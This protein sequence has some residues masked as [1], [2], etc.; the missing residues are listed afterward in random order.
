[1]STEETPERPRRRRLTVVAVAAAVLVAGGGAAY[2]S[3]A[4]ADD[5]APT[6][7]G[8]GSKP[9]PLALDHLRQ[10]EAATGSRS[11]IAPGEP[12][13]AGGAYRAQGELPKGPGTASV[14]RTEGRVTES[15]VAAVAEVLGMA[16]NP[17][18]EHG[19]WT[20]R[21]SKD[22]SGPSLT[23]SDERAAGSWRFSRYMPQRDSVCAAP[24]KPGEPRS[25]RSCGGEPGEASTTDPVSPEEA[26]AAVRP[27]LKAMN[28]DGARLDASAVD[29]ALR[30][31]SAEPQVGGLPVRHWG[32]VFTVGADGQL[33][34]GRG[35]LAEMTKGAEYPVLS[36][37]KTLK[38]LNKHQ[39]G[40]SSNLAS[41]ASPEQPGKAQTPNP[42]GGDAG[43]TDAGPPCAAPGPLGVTS[44]TDAEFGL[45]MQ[46]SDTGP[47]LVP[48]WIFE[49]E[50]KGGGGTHEVTYPA[51]RPDYLVAGKDGTS[52]TGTQPETPPGTGSE[53]TTRQALTSYRAD[54]RTL[55]VT[56]Y[57]GVCDTY[58]GE[59]KAAK[60]KVTVSVEP[61]EPRPKGPCIA[62]AKE[63]TV[64]VELDEPLGDR[65]VV[66]GRDGEQLPRK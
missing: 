53:D 15:E 48:S 30:E 42:S 9:A 10:T 37:A 60:E 1:M 61:R 26:K 57:G 43:T 18:R 41:C 63:Q 38:E 66:D 7:D 47:L 13:P 32:A 31:V 21:D 39:R 19:G 12:D 23:V 44:V 64:K 36:A 20:V 17:K 35:Q 51:V 52:G 56:F 59:A 25:T 45:A 65:K 8:G 33:V 50:R 3:S 14:F 27:A 22:G 2:W 16:G 29:G 11:D 46:P 58:R 24:Q 62:M 40:S 4:T 5:D 55:T 28:L 34:S 6:A 54:G 49:I